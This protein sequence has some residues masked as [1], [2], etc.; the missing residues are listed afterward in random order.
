M[1]SNPIKEFLASIPK[2]VDR[3]IY[4][5]IDEA[6]EMAG[7]DS[8]AQ[9]DIQNVAQE[10]INRNVDAGLIDERER[11]DS[12]GRSG[13]LFNAINHG[14]LAY[15]YGDSPIIR[16]MLQGKEYLQQGQEYLS[17]RDPRTQYID[18]MNNLV[19]YDL[20]DLSE[21]EALE[22]MLNRITDTQKTMRE[23]GVD[24][25]I[26]GKHFYLNPQDY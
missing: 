13:D 12:E 23:G 26:P 15:R 17:G 8:S 5:V 21:E 1:A 20:V 25:L 11:I 9:K 24:A 16:G 18:R 7:I 10:F 4:S 14:L 6:G 22:E 2:R 19:G 3:G